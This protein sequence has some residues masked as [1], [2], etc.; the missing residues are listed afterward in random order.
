MFEDRE[1]WL[2][3]EYAAEEIQSEMDGQY[4]PEEDYFDFTPVSVY[5]LRQKLIDGEVILPFQRK[6][7]DGNWMGIRSEAESYGLDLENLW[8]V[9][10]YI[11]Y[12]TPLFFRH[13]NCAVEINTIVAR[14]KELLPKDGAI[15][16]VHGARDE[17][18]KRM[19]PL[20][21]DNQQLLSILSQLIFF[22]ELNV[23]S[24]VRESYSPSETEQ[25]AYAARRY[26]NL[27]KVL[28]H[29]GEAFTGNVSKNSKLFF[30][31]KLLYFSKIVSSRDYLKPNPE[32]L[33]GA[34]RTYPD[35]PSWYEPFNPEEW[36]SRNSLTIQ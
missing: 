24:Q 16:E 33:K 9:I 31:S 13:H 10:C 17:N 11:S 23:N 5:Q 19:K 7:F 34:L 1:I 29:K 27:F 14:L 35:D 32:Q 12:M 30:T 22:S 21:V 8:N 15:L 36:F 2:Y 28:R 18:G 4:F 25:A 20:R 3:S 6:D 26:M